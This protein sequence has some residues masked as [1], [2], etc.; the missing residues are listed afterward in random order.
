MKAMILAAGLGTRMQPLTNSTPKPLLKI[1][2]THLIEFHLQKLALSGFT[3]V[4]INTHWL[5]EQIP[6]ALGSGEK[7]GLNIHYSYEPELLETAGGIQNA[8]PLLV[9]DESEHFLLINGDVYFEWDLKQWLKNASD[10]IQTAL[11]YLALVPNPE[12]HLQGD[13]GFAPSSNNL[14]LKSSEHEEAFTYAGVGVYKVSLFSN[15]Q[16]GY[17]ALGPILK[18]EIEN[19]AIKGDLQQDYWLDVGSIERLDLLTKRLS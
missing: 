17:Q 7:W 9:D 6:A 4:V 8:L 5:A 18:T 1:G 16:K 12:H 19:Y 14:C 15:L 10:Q 3:D 2:Q 11:A 13:F